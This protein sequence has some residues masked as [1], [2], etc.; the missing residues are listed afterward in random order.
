[1]LPMRR[2]F[3]EFFILAL[4]LLTPAGILSIVAVDIGTQDPSNTQKLLGLFG[5]FTVSLLVNGV[6]LYPGLY[7]ACTPFGLPALMRIIRDPF[8]ISLTT[9]N[10]LLA[11][12]ILCRNLEKFILETRE[13]GSD[14]K[15]TI[16]GLTAIASLGLL[17]FAIGEHLNLM[18]L[19]FAAWFTGTPLGVDQTLRMLITALPA[20]LGAPS[21]AIA[22]GLQKLHL[23]RELLNLYFVVYDWLTRIGCIET[24]IGTTT[25]VLVLL[26]ADRRRLRLRIPMIIGT[27]AV[28][29]VVGIGSGFLGHTLLVSMLGGAGTQP[30]L[31][32]G[33]QSLLPSLKP[34]LLTEPPALIPNAAT[35]R[36]SGRKLQAGIV[37]NNTPWVLLGS[38]GEWVGFDVDLLKSISRILDSELELLPG[39]L[40][41]LEGLLASNRLDCV[42]GGIGQGSRLQTP[43]QHRIS[44]NEVPLAVLVRDKD[45]RDRVAR[46]DSNSTE[47]IRVAMVRTGGDRA[48]EMMVRSHLT[49][50]ATRLR[51]RFIPIDGVMDFIKTNQPP[52]DVLL[53]SAEAGSSL[54]ILHPDHSM[55][56][57]FGKDLRLPLVFLISDRFPGGLEGAKD[58]L[59]QATSLGVQ[60]RL[61][62]HWFRLLDPED[63]DATP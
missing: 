15:P 62:D 34:V 61:V 11:L 37:T 22:E 40:S 35:N 39:S 26:A 23:P 29:V 31:L 44:Y 19:P 27:G 47:E 17:V 2:L 59:S 52:A 54:A 4:D 56:P 57:I 24:L 20:S 36:A 3:T 33:R 6:I 30:E 48:T 50:P 63:G 8:I 5:M 42:I 28:S 18:F 12:P 43:I 25:G 1:V 51:V 32:L 41:E 38:H 49:R 9:G 16:D 14:E 60:Q 46:L 55:L 10:I 45:I 7:L 53:T 21:A 13:A 58:L